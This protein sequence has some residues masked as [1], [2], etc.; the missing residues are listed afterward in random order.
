MST[1]RPVTGRNPP[2]SARVHTTRGIYTPRTQFTAVRNTR[3][4]LTVDDIVS[5]KRDKQILLQER[6][7]LKAKLARYA[8]FNRHSKAPQRNQQIATSLEKQ[9]HTLEQVTAT[10]RAEIA[11]LFLSDKASLITEL[12]EESKML[13]LEL[14]RLQK[15]KQN[16]E[17]ELR[18]VIAQIEDR[19]QRYSPAVLQKQQKTIK[20][21][22]KEIEN[23]KEKNEQLK[24][25]LQE[26]EKAKEELKKSEENDQMLR[27][28]EAM[29][30]KI[31]K[32]QQEIAVMDRQM[33]QMKQEHSVAM[34]NI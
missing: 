25:K 17:S 6:S 2:H 34:S 22:E 18:S 27:A 26:A 13:Y 1:F 12:Q 11:E 31:R 15:E 19:N 30:A 24:T 10:K 14:N 29:K 16:V 8:S 33:E 21:L 9:V 4:S 23:Q 32:E 20:H 7:M 28:I 3:E 5:L